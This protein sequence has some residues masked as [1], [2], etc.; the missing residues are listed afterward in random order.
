MFM[1]IQYSCFLKAMGRSKK[2]VIES[3]LHCI[4]IYDDEFVILD[5]QKKSKWF[6][7]WSRHR[8]NNNNRENN[9]CR[10]SKFRGFSFTITLRQKPKGVM[11]MQ[12]LFLV[13]QRLMRVTHLG[14]CLRVIV[15]EKV[16]NLEKITSSVLSV[17]LL[18]YESNDVYG[19]M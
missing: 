8:L 13:I 12:S 4:D 9:R 16:L 3:Y 19:I 18:I 2:N 7:L 11:R 5:F 14:F 10:F 1:W 17:S 15:K 6:F